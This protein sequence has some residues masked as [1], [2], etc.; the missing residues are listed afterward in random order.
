MSILHSTIVMLRR[1]IAQQNPLSSH[2]VLADRR[3]WRGAPYQ[4][5]FGREP[6]LL[7]FSLRPSLSLTSLCGKSWRGLV[8]V[9]CQHWLRSDRGTAPCQPFKQHG[10]ISRVKR[11]L[12]STSFFQFLP[13]VFVYQTNKPSRRPTN[14]VWMLSSSLTVLC[15]PFRSYTELCLRVSLLYKL[16]I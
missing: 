14:A 1:P 8:S 15:Q 13:K 6:C 2:G 9:Y 11:C 4:N 12:F 7:Q 16:I 10:G 5:V 3:S